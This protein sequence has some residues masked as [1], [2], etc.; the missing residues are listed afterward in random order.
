M[1][2]ARSLFVSS[3]ADADIWIVSCIARAG[4]AAAAHDCVGAIVHLGQG[5]FAAELHDAAV[6]PIAGHFHSIDA[7][8]RAIESHFHHRQERPVPRRRSRKA[9]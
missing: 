2:Q 5:V 1:A 7:A 6:A 8:A 9:R 4:K 3:S